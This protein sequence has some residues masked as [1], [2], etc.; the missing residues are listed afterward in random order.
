MFGPITIALEGPDGYVYK[1]E[2][3]NPTLGQ[4]EA[5][6]KQGLDDVSPSVV[7]SKVEPFKSP[8]EAPFQLIQA[9]LEEWKI[10][11]SGGGKNFTVKRD[12]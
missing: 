11:I 9:I 5:W 12:R 6:Q 2:C 1:A 10:Q 7:I 3:V 4:I 8:K